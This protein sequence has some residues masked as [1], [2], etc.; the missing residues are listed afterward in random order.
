MPIAAPADAVEGQ[1]HA[2]P[3]ALRPLGL[4]DVPALAH[5]ALGLEVRDQ[6]RDGRPREARAPGDLR[7]AHHAAFQQRVDDPKA[8]ELTQRFQ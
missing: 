6:A 7:A 2:G 5:Q 4:L 8:V 3:A 1:Q